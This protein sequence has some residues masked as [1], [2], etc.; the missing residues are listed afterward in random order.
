MATAGPCRGVWVARMKAAIEA[1]MPTDRSM[2]PV[3]MVSVWQAARMASGM[4]ARTVTPTQ[5]S[6]TVPGW[7]S[8]RPTTSRI[9]RPV[10][11]TSGRS[12]KSR[13]HAPIVSQVGGPPVD[14][15]WAVIV[16]SSEGSGGCPA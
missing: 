9:S 1:I 4:A 16:G 6:S 11:G 7:M 13:R 15:A 3:S 12:R 2:P 8:S 14:A 5:T 10:N